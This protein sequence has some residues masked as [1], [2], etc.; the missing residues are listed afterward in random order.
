MQI[1]CLHSKG[2]DPVFSKF[3]DKQLN[4]KVKHWTAA[5]WNRAWS[6]FKAVIDIIAAIDFLEVVDTYLGY[7]FGQLLKVLLVNC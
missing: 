6:R 2:I 3:G 7:K 4:L 5:W 1:K